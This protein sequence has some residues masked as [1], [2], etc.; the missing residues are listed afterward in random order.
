MF[1]FFRLLPQNLV[2]VSCQQQLTSSPV[3]FTE[4]QRPPEVEEDTD[5]FRKKALLAATASRWR[6]AAEM[7]DSSNPKWRRVAVRAVQLQENKVNGGT[8]HLTGSPGSSKLNNVAPEHHL[9]EVETHSPP[10]GPWGDKVIENAAVHVDMGKVVGILRATHQ[11][12]DEINH[13]EKGRMVE[14]D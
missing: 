4:E 7:G 2:S 5:H 6:A 3:E 9:A 10:P 8:P 14:N 12:E 1:N 11:L 13:L